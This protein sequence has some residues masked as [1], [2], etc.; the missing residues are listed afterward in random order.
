MN[1]NG[2]YIDDEI[3]EFVYRHLDFKDKINFAKTT[4]DISY[5][6]KNRVRCEIFNYINYDYKLF[7]ECL[8]RFKY[9]LEEQSELI[10]KSLNITMV[11]NVKGKY[12]DLRFIFEVC[13]YLKKYHPKN[14]FYK[15]AYEKKNIANREYWRE[16]PLL[17]HLLPTT[18]LDVLQLM[19]KDIYNSISFN[20]FE[21]M[22]NIESKMILVPLKRDFKPILWKTNDEKW[23]YLI[24]E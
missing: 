8:N 1:V 2:L 18:G 12:V 22:L 4:K 7:Y 21:T 3:I 6:Y 20:R 9:T 15:N 19:I 17:L 11:H 16:P 10:E 5:K 14:N 23:L 24:R 13:Y